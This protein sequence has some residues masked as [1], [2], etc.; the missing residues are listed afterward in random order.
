[1]TRIC[2]VSS[3]HT[4]LDVRIF[5]KECVSLARAG[6]EV[7][8][9]IAA[10]D[11][12]REEAAAAGVTVHV[13]P[14]PPKSR[15]QR[16][17]SGIYHCTRAALRVDARVYHLHDIELLP[18][19]LLLRAMGRRVVYDVHEDVPTDLLTKEWIPQVLRVILRPFVAGF[20]AVTARFFLEVV[21]ATPTIAGRFRRHNRDTACVGNFPL[22]GELTSGYNDWS[23]KRHQIAYIGGIS[24]IRGIQEVTR[25]LVLTQS[26]VRLQ[27]V[28][29]FSDPEFEG[30]IKQEPGWGKVDEL[31]FLDRSGV[32][33]VLR[34]A[35]AGVVTLHPV[36]NYLDALPVKMFEYMSAGVPVIASD[37]PLWRDIIE[38]SR[39]GICVD[40]ED[41]QAIADA[42]DHLVMHPAEAE[43]MG[44]NGQLAVH[45]RYNW[46][47]EEGKLLAFYRRLLAA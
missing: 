32:A 1:M 28:G 25:A 11:L 6:Y 18:V 22:L 46:T 13:L 10:T 40:P 9:I 29:D 35:V 2:H 15:L 23:I 36:I 19:G 27:L 24:R 38:S 34:D 26:D 30:L 20:E 47:I 21:A 42:M 4:G 33:S 37:F 16:I 43:T 3:V 7:H 8:L 44:R 14:L 17:F 31:G 45:E 5:R 41:P 39:C 12:Q